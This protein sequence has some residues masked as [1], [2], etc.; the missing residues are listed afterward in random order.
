MNR[1]EHFPIKMAKFSLIIVYWVMLLVTMALYLNTEDVQIQ[2]HVNIPA[3]DV[4]IQPEITIT[5][6][7][8]NGTITTSQQPP[9]P[10]QI[11]GLVNDG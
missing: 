6:Y 9:P 10:S 4:D 1:K 5:Q 2:I 11:D 8:E 7:T 3:V